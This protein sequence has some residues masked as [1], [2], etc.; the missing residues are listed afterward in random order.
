MPNAKLVA[1]FDGTAR[2]GGPACATVKL[3]PAGWK[4]TK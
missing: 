3:T 4:V 2:D 1:E